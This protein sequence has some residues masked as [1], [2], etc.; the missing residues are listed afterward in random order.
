MPQSSVHPIEQAT[1]VPMSLSEANAFVTKHHRHH[2]PM[3]G[4]K[5]SIGLA[6][7]QLRGVI[8]V[9]RPI[10]R[11]RD[12]GLTLEVTRCCTDGIRNGCSKLYR[13]AWRVAINLGFQRL[14]T[15][16]LPDE[17]GASLRGAGFRLVGKTKGGNWNVPS[18]P[19]SDTKLHLQGQKLLWEAPSSNE[20]PQAHT[21]P[22]KESS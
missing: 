10:S 14:I 21:L 16:T 22:P 1:L 12:D 9:G 3:V 5:Y 4:H 17:G 19:R 8:I 15:Y 13:A 6:N 2:K 7:G 18:R 11:H 20:P